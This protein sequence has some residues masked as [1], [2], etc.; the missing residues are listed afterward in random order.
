MSEKDGKAFMDELKK[1]IKGESGVKLTP[2][3]LSTAQG[4]SSLQQMAGGDIVSA[5]AF[6]PLERIASATEQTAAN[7]DPS[8][9]E[10]IKDASP[11]RSPLGY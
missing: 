7:T 1:Q 5:M 3:G 4:A 11:V 10:V 8:K 6:T 9:K 2:L